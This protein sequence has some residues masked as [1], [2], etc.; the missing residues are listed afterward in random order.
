M[1]NNLSTQVD[2][3]GAGT[4]EGQAEMPGRHGTAAYYL[5]AGYQGRL[6]PA[7]LAQK[8]DNYVLQ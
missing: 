1:R 8:C 5:R 6:N 4:D 7:A 2:N 3:V